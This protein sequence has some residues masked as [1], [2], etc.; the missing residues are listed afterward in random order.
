MAAKCG[1]CTRTL[2]S[3]N[4]VRFD[5]IFLCYWCVEFPFLGF[6]DPVD[7]DREKSEG[8]AADAAWRETYD[9]APNPQTEMRKK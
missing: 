1:I 4:M 5:P 7:V 8:R 2:D 6:S 9:D 3:E